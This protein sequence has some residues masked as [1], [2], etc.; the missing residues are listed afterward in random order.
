[1]FY[2]FITNVLDGNSLVHR[3]FFMYCLF[4]TEPQSCAVCLLFIILIFITERFLRNQIAFFDSVCCRKQMS[5][6]NTKPSLL[7]MLSRF[8]VACR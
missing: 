4:A 5:K 6:L 3:K 8:F 7:V 1:M 2:C